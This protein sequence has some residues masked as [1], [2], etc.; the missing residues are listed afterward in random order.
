MAIGQILCMYKA[1]NRKISLENVNL[2]LFL[3]IYI[4]KHKN[5]SLNENG[6]LII[7]LNICISIRESSLY[8]NSN[9]VFNA[10][11]VCK[12]DKIGVKKVGEVGV[13]HSSRR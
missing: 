11:F 8:D 3:I 4:L 1:S 6:K 10:Y 12:P 5:K 7:F 13:T 9:C 2:C